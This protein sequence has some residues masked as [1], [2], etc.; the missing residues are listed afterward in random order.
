[1]GMS[2]AIA[3]MTREEKNNTGIPIQLKER[4]VQEKRMPYVE[5]QIH[6]G[7]GLSSRSNVLAYTQEDQ[8]ENDTG[9]K[10][11][12]DAVETGKVVEIVQRM[13]DNVVQRCEEEEKTENQGEV[14]DAAIPDAVRAQLRDGNRM[15]LADAERLAKDFLGEG[16]TEPSP[17]SGRFVSEDG[18]RVFRKG[19][20]DI[21]GKHGGGPHVNFELLKDN[22]DKPGKKMVTKDIHI[23]LLDE[24]LNEA[25]KKWRDSLKK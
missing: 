2:G 15:T 24:D 12:T 1:M 16:Y 17:G 21:Y 6:Y 19:E 25:Y 5:A 9:P 7:L 22:P 8:V 20:N 4:M 10:P 18:R 11:Q 14:E 3:R 23:F 13:G